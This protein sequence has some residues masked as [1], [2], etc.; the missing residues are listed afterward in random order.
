MNKENF[1]YFVKTI[2]LFFLTSYVLDKV[3]YLSIGHIEKQV[4]SGQ[5]VGKVNH[6]LSVKDTSDLIVFGHS[7]AKNHINTSNGYGFNMGM[8]GVKIAFHN[9]LIKLLPKKLKQTVLLHLD[10]EAFFNENYDGSDITALKNLFHRNKTVNNEIKKLKQNNPLSNFYYSI[11][12]NG[13]VLRILNDYFYPNYDFKNYSGY[14]PIYPSNSQILV[15]KKKLEKYEFKKKCNQNLKINNLYDNYLNE[16]ISFCKN[17]NKKLIVYTSPKYYDDCDDDNILF[18]SIMKD[19]RIN[20][21]DYTNFFESNNN[22]KYWKDFTHLSAQ[23]ADIFT[24][25]IKE[26]T[27]KP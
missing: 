9:T 19:K 10:P 14:D 27:F 23:G 7:R 2:F 6:Y 22:I 21:F 20:Y 24:K 25:K 16:I 5:N 8:D 26:L 12:F 15:F 17:N 1:I 4:F 13:K 18:K 3:I 11:T